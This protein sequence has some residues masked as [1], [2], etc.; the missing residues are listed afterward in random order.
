MLFQTWYITAGRKIAIECMD[1]MPPSLLLLEPQ[2]F[3]GLD[4][5]CW[6]E[7][8]QEHQDPWDNRNLTSSTMII[9]PWEQCCMGGGEDS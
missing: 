7:A 3:G 4:V 8:A 2:P 9:V 1:E 6:Y 5:A